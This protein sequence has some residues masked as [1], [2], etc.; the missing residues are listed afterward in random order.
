MKSTQINLKGTTLV[1]T[2]AGF[3]FGILS[4]F[5]F[6][7]TD[8]E[9]TKSFALN[10]GLLSI[11]VSV[12]SV[13]ASSL[14]ETKIID[15][16]ERISNKFT[17]EIS[18]IDKEREKL[19]T[20]LDTHKTTLTSHETKINLLE[21][22]VNEKE[23]I[24]N[25]LR[26]AFS[27]L[28]RETEVKQQELDE[29][30]NK[31]NTDRVDLQNEFID[32]FTSDLKYKIEH[33][34]GSLS[35]SVTAKLRNS[36]Y[37]GIHDKLSTFYQKLSRSLADTQALLLD[38]R[39]IEFST[40]EITDIYFAISDEIASCKVQYRNL[41]NTVERLTLKELEE[42]LSERRNP[43][44]YVAAN[45]V[46]TALDNHDN[47][48]ANQKLKFEAA[49]NL[50]FGNLNDLRNEVGNLIGQI[51]EKNLEIANLKTEIN[52]HRSPL[53]WI[54][55]NSRELTIGNLIIDYFWKGGTGFYLDRSF[56]E[57]DGY[58]LKL[59]YQID[60]N[61]RVIGETELNQS[62]EE[63]Q[64]FCRT[65][66]PITFTYS[67]AK[68]LMVAKVI[69]RERPKVETSIE[70]IRRICKPPELFAANVGGYE[71]WRITG[72]SQAGK[73]PT[74]QLI[75]DAIEKYKGQTKVNFRLFNPQAGSKK[76][77]WKYK[78]EGKNSTDT[79]K[80][81]K[82]LNDE[83]SGRQSKQK[84]TNIFDLF[85]FDEIDSVVD[86]KGSSEV[87]KPLTY[88]IKQASH[89][90]VGILIIGQSSAANVV[91]GM[92]WSDWNSTAQCHIGE[93]AKLFIESRWKNESERRDE[94][95]KQYEIIRNYYE[96]KNNENGLTVSDYG[97]YRFAFMTIPNQKPFFIELPPFIFADAVR[98]VPTPCEP[99]AEVTREDCD[100]NA[101]D[102]KG[103]T[104]PKCGGKNIGSK[105]TKFHRC[106]DCS[107]CWKK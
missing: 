49:L 23:I 86:E 45:K 91:S 58:E 31:E 101:T 63:L 43:K 26:I 9:N 14:M 65:I 51:D 64:Q 104:C 67:G 28:Q 94:Y 61:P 74:A 69:L 70:S 44:N 11:G 48:Y 42:E 32:L 52:K 47:Y 5:T 96:T 13:V 55:A 95:L 50:Q 40:T 93:N 88:A 19:K 35:N 38:L 66:K 41:L 80:G 62:S 10:I 59:Y 36:K 71:R 27:N 89:Q 92:T 107:K 76:D 103:I 29:K 39:E 34:Y 24:I 15:E 81:F 75:A 57:S 12:G 87:K 78:A 90:D 102:E 17:D 18:K 77:N 83:I 46:K 79:V 82:I 8:N 105:G 22:A 85:I 68:S 20:Q 4:T 21:K 60:R 1:A 56:Y 97:F 2:S 106:R 16:S 73:S 30:L 6:V 98:S 37:E 84:S 100:N 33:S 25:N 7:T 53:K 54:N 3:M 72:G 99:T